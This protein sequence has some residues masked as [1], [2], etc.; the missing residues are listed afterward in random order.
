M[1]TTVESAVVCEAHAAQWTSSLRKGI[2]SNCKFGTYRAAA[3]KVSSLSIKA[4]EHPPGMCRAR[5]AL[6]PVARQSRYCFLD[7]A[8][9]KPRWNGQSV[10]V[11]LTPLG[12][13]QQAAALQRN[14]SLGY[15]ALKNATRSDSSCAVSTKPK[16]CS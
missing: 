9:A 13:N 16:R 8:I 7:L 12:A 3:T 6:L 15:R 11:Q 2:D 10:R 5:T 4:S 1:E 14:A